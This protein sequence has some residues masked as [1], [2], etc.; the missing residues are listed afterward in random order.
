MPANKLN[1]LLPLNSNNDELNTRAAYHQLWNLSFDDQGNITSRPGHR[2]WKDVGTNANAYGYWWQKQDRLVVVSNKVLYLYDRYGAVT[3]VTTSLSSNKPVYFSDDGERLYFA[4]NGRIQQYT[5]GDASTVALADTTAPLNCTTPIVHD[6]YLLGNQIGSDI[7]GVGEFKEPPPIAGQ[8]YEWGAD[9]FFSAEALPDECVALVSLWRQ[10]IVFCKRHIEFWIN[11]GATPFSRSGNVITNQGV[12]SAGAI[13]VAVD[14]IYCMTHRRQILQMQDAQMTDITAGIAAD[15]KKLAR[16]DDVEASY[17]YAG[18][19]HY[20]LFNFPSDGVSFVYDIERQSWAKW[21]AW[22]RENARW[23][24]NLCS[25]YVQAI[26]WNKW[27]GFTRDGR[28]LEIDQTIATDVEN[29]VRCLLR[30]GFNDAGV[31]ERKFSRRIQINA[32][33]GIGT[34]DEANPMNTNFAPV[35]VL[36]WREDDT[37]AWRERE[38]DMGKPGEYFQRIAIQGCGSYYQRQY[39][40]EYMDRPA[41][42]IRDGF[43]EVEPGVY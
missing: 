1:F 27:F 11:D 12:L 26:N 7:V 21:G 3:T 36:R 8:P 34:F 13:A 23:N 6:G 39:E 10:V 35:A 22:D 19:D 30:T 5:P 37:M 20:V 14:T 38:L 33:R 28:I 2:L 15:L 40:F 25:R 9:L 31:P 16:V 29:P 18:P 4:A 24:A 41:M 17:V 43:E 32:R 42:T